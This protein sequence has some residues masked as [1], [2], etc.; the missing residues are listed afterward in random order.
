M[1]FG[2]GILYTRPILLCGALLCDSACDA[3]VLVLGRL[4]W[5]GHT[6]FTSPELDDHTDR[7]G[8]LQSSGSLWSN[9]HRNTHWVWSLS[10][11][12]SDYY[13]FKVP[14]HWLACRAAGCKSQIPLQ[15]FGW[16]PNPLTTWPLTSH[17]PGCSLFIHFAPRWRYIFSSRQ[18]EWAWDLPRL[19]WMMKR[20]LMIKSH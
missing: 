8:S 15:P 9:G 14:W 18:Y 17:W 5:R 7:L 10:T 20:S 11:V 1:A 3:I 4:T 12:F 2:K 19:D 13:C 16:E 6:V